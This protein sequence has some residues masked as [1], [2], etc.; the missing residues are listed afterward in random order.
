MFLKID[1]EPIMAQEPIRQIGMERIRIYLELFSR[2]E[3]SSCLCCQPL[4]KALCFHQ[5]CLATTLPVLMAVSGQKEHSLSHVR[6][7]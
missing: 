6:C 1:Y 7:P 4:Q 3:G 2:K 5:T